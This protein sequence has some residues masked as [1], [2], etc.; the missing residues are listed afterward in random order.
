M[1]TKPHTAATA[2]EA[3]AAFLTFLGGTNPPP[4]RRAG[5]FLLS[6]VPLMPSL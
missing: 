5:P 6:S 2:N 4:V 1:I 3:N